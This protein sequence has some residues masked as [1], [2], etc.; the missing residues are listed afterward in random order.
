M[1]ADIAPAIATDMEQA[2]QQLDQ[3]RSTHRPR[4]RIPWSTA[5]E[6]AQPHGMTARAL[7]LDYS[8]LK[9]LVHAQL[10]CIR[11]KHLP[12]H[13]A[14]AQRSRT[15]P[16]LVRNHRAIAALAFASGAGA[17]SAPFVK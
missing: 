13:E 14:S 8:R 9:K 16:A 7:H 2:R 3:F 5:A 11:A 10:E 17:T 12:L 1:K 4:Y 15:C 6:L